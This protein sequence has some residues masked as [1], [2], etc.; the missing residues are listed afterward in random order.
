MSAGGDEEKKLAYNAENTLV[1]STTSTYLLIFGI[2][3]NYLQILTGTPQNIRRKHH[4]NVVHGHACDCLVR[5]VTHYL[6]EVDEVDEDVAVVFRDHVENGQCS[7]GVL[8]VL[9]AVVVEFG[10]ND[11]V[12]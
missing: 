4:G 1:T 5:R 10:W 2:F 7:D 6:E 12:N 11:G 3:Q 9:N 8:T